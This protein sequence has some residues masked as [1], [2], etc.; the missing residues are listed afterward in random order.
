MVIGVHGLSQ[1]VLLAIQIALLQL[2]NLLLFANN[3]LTATLAAR[4]LNHA[5][6]LWAVKDQ[7]WALYMGTGK[8]SIA[9]ATSSPAVGSLLIH[10]ITLLVGFASEM[11]F[12]R[13]LLHQLFTVVL[14]GTTLFLVPVCEYWLAAQLTVVLGHT[15][16]GNVTFG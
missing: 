9:T 10:R 3:L 5:V 1:A 15:A 16:L 6:R 13:I 14:H 8:V 7:L 2:L 11:A 4:V 12:G